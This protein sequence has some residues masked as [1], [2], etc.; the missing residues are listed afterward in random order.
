[1]IWFYRVTVHIDILSEQEVQRTWILW[2]Q[3][4]NLGEQ[5]SESKWER[6]RRDRAEDSSA[7]DFID[8]QK[9][10]LYPR[11]FILPINAQQVI[12]P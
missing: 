8:A 1:M 6:C 5:L 3:K 7:F 9:P 12:V 10:I 4:G 11:I 2:R